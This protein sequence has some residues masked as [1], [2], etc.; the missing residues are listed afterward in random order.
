MRAAVALAGVTLALTGCAGA[1]GQRA[2]ELLQ[3]ALAASATVESATFEMDVTVA[4]EGTT[5][6]ADLRGGGYM[7]G[8]RAGDMYVSFRM[9]GVPGFDGRFDM[10][11]KDGR[12]HVGMDGEWQQVE[13]GEDDRASAAASFG[14]RA[15]EELARYVKDV[16]VNEQQVV[17]GERS[18]TIAGELDTAAMLAGLAK[19]ASL[20]DAVGGAPDV[21]ELAEGLGD[22][23]IVLVISEE[24]KL[25]TAAIVR[26]SVTGEG[27]TGD[28]AIAYRLTS[29]NEPV[30]F[31][32]TA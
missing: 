5:M 20:S 17:N 27:G 13:L 21:G 15:F 2:Q 12:G 7:Q 25:I 3:Q 1:E 28:I 9:S 22:T 16:R 24:T 32:K 10:V 18:I 6:R 29:T 4:A 31:P 8:P 19:L 11:M 30:R 14:P 26:L 23:K